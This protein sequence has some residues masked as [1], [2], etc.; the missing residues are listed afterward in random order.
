MQ[1]DYTK[2]VKA[3]PSFSMNMRWPLTGGVPSGLFFEGDVGIERIYVAG[4]QD[5]SVRIW[6]ATHPV[7]TLLHIIVGKV[8]HLLYTTL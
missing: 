7:L 4:Y 6:D 2:R 3:T 8:R 5:G 1:K